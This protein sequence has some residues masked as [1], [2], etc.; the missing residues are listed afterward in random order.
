MRGRIANRPTP[1]VSVLLPFH[2]ASANLDQCLASI[3]AQTL[4]DFELL[5]VDD[6][7]EDRS[8]QQVLAA[9]GQ[10]PRLR[11]LRP[12]R[13]GLIQALNLG[14]REAR[15][16][17]VARMDAD[18]R[19]RPQRLWRQAEYLERHRE[20]A[21]VGSRVWAFPR[22]AVGKGF[23]EYLAWQDRCLSPDDLAQ[24]VY[25]EAPL[26]NPS[27]MLRRVVVLALGGYRDGPF[28]ED[29]DLWLRMAHAGYPVA[30]LD[31]VLLDWRLSATSYSRTDSRYSRPAF[32]RIR[33]AYLARDPRLRE[34]RPLVFWGAG[35][36]T[37]RR[38]DL[39]VARGYRPAAYVDIDPRKSGGR[40][41]A[42]PCWVRRRGAAGQAIRALLRD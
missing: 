32:D 11:L 7:S 31:E 37:R 18:D 5:A 1:R 13:C 33:A 42:C 34:G 41:I 30:K 10:D 36:K 14:L 27:A 25:R 6:G 19:M 15:S 40:F 22:Q 2:N 21:A 8:V 9:A 39:L 16:P 17:L 29:Y 26:V 23:Q 28:P 35:R 12:G 24:E 3:L 38:L 20:V 4:V